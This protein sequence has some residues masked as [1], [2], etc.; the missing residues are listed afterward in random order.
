MT[1]SVVMTL[2]CPLSL[3]TLIEQG[4]RLRQRFQVRRPKRPL[5]IERAT[6]LFL[7]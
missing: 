2:R 3:P 6:E 5:Q 1:E 7:S 4:G